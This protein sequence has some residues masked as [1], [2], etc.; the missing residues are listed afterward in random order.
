[1]SAS[2]AL[3]SASFSPGSTTTSGPSSQNSST[4]PRPAVPMSPRNSLLKRRQRKKDHKSSRKPR[5]SAGTRAAPDGEP[6]E[7][8]SGSR[9][10]LEVI[11]TCLCPF[12]V[13]GLQFSGSRR[14]GRSRGDQ[15]GGPDRRP[16]QRLW[17]PAAGRDIRHRNAVGAA[18][19]PFHRA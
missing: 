4:L 1:M 18:T 7:T 9:P 19:Y 6:S 11:I 3:V 2:A 14:S 17:R 12:S 8:P 10:A 16:A 5:P 15:R 13:F